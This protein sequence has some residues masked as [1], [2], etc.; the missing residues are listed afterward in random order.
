MAGY[1]QAVRLLSID[2]I[3]A[4]L[5]AV[6]D[7]ADVSAPN[8]PRE[9]LVRTVERPFE[10][11][12]DVGTR[13]SRLE[14]LLR[15]RE[16]RRAV[17]LTIYVRMT[18]AV[19]RGIENGE[20]NDG[21]WM[22]DYVVSFA[23]YYRRAFLAF[24]RGNIDDVPEPWK[25][26]FGTAVNGDNLVA[27]D[28]F[29]GINAHINYD[30]AFAVRDVGIQ[31]NREQKRADHRAIDGILARIIDAQQEA[32]AEI[33]AP[34]VD[35]IDVSLR[36]FDED[37]SLFTMTQGREQAWRIAVILTNV[38]LPPVRGY[39]RWILRTTATG[40]ALFVLSPTLNPELM[41]ALERI[42]EN[43]ELSEILEEVENC[44]DEE[45]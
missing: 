3:R 29:L 39:A 9:P 19:K 30:L 25:L 15:D 44:I 2:N 23:E 34:G 1:T 8:E 38:G 7:N 12:E 6:R 27:Q 17:F 4:I 28:S 31:L 10:S 32:L 35:A 40:G 41:D 42:E 21:D 13:L 5:R 20:F 45:E 43:K 26:A 11:V 33:Y 14:R 36:R 22:R 16:D 37:L 18:R 24:E